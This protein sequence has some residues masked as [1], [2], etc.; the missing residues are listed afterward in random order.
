MLLSVETVFSQKSDTLLQD[1][2]K[3][4]GGTVVLFKAGTTVTFNSRGNV[5]SGTLAKNTRLW[6]PCPNVMFA[7]GTVVNFN[8]KGKVISGVIAFEAQYWTAGPY[9][10]LKK[11]SPVIFNQ[12]GKLISGIPE[13][14]INLEI[15]KDFLVLFEKDMLNTLA[16]WILKDVFIL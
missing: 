8:S 6:T 14:D 12:E 9:I 5:I 16:G 11:G 4:T 3:L 10:Y 13:S 7:E 15:K 2:E 1:T